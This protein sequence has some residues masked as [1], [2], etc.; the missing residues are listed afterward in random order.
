VE[1]GYRFERYYDTLFLDSSILYLVA[2][3]FPERVARLPGSTVA[4]LLR[5]IQ[6]GWY[7]TL[8][9][10]TT[11][12]ALDAY[13]ARVGD[14]KLTLSEI[15]KDGSAKPIVTQP[16]VLV[17]G[18]FDAAATALRVENGV[19]LHAWYS[20]TQAGFDR[21]SPTTELKQ[22]LEI[23]REYTDTTGKAVSTATLGAELDVHLKIR[24]TEADSIGNIAIVDLLPGGFEAVIQP[25]TLPQDSDAAS[26]DAAPAT[27][28]WQSPVGVAGS[29][30]SPEYAD[31]RDDR[32]VIYG[33][34]TRNVG[35]FVYRIRA[36]NAGTFVVPPAYGES[37]YDRTVQARSLGGKIEVVK[38]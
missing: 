13:G 24:A 8:S 3:H 30:W 18:A 9:S 32:V 20:V 16:G 28:K 31:V 33:T 36:T 29:T 5:P 14:G 26:T 17:R 10:A 2:K 27:P 7:N 4:T 38:K 23:V 6:R 15:Q 37:M 21:S 1:N 22:G 12:L 34:A 11:I 19:D 35:E 25:P